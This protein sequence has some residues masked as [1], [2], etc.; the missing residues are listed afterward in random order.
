L[1]Q[2]LEVSQER[3]NELDLQVKLATSEHDIELKDISAQC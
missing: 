2:K 1:I 3:V